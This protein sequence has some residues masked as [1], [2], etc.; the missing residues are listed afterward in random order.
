MNKLDAISQRSSG[1]R[2]LVG[3]VKTAIIGCGAG[4]LILSVSKLNLAGGIALAIEAPASP[5]PDGSS[6]VLEEIFTPQ[7]HG[8][9]AA[10][11]PAVLPLSEEEVAALMDVPAEE[12]EEPTEELPAER[13]GAKRPEG[14]TGSAVTF[15]EHGKVFLYGQPVEGQTAAIQDKTTGRVGGPLPAHD[16]VG[17]DFFS[18][19]L[20]IGNS[21]IVG[22]EKS[23]LLNTK[24]YASIG[25]S[26]R[27]FFEKA[28]M[29]VT[30]PET[31]KLVYLTTADA[32]AVCN[33]YKKVFLL[34]G[35]NEM[36]WSIEGFI[37]E[38]SALID[39]ILAIRPDAEIYVQKILP[40]NETVY[41][42]TATNPQDY[43]SN[44]RIVR[45]NASIEVMA[46]QKQVFILNPGEAMVGEDGIIPADAVPADGIHLSTPYLRRWAD[47]LRTHTAEQ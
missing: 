8:L 30:D 12:T 10:L 39:T 32:L 38:Y 34:F 1:M 28:N 42:A 41:A 46:T 47:Y 20:I 43:F 18:D 26:V 11:S 2:K 40:M 9:R 45:F 19:A 44:E 24:Y 36:G 27:Q 21:Q 37:S 22:L 13:P 14:W 25:L 33:D 16:P 5:A 23:G 31:G 4:L 15:D 6:M 7:A 3:L 17:D 29:A 35:I